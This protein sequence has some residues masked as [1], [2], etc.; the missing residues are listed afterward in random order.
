MTDEEEVLL[1]MELSVSLCRRIEENYGPIEGWRARLRYNCATA[2]D[3]Q[4]L[5]EQ[6]V[7]PNPSADQWPSPWVGTIPL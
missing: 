5:D 2:Q 3:I 4:K 1:R 7:N 6:F